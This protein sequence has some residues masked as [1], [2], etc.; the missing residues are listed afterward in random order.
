MQVEVLTNKHHIYL[1]KDGRVSMA[2]E[3]SCKRGLPLLSLS[4]CNNPQPSKLAW[5]GADATW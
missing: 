5:S 1:T 3:L 4:E 2:G